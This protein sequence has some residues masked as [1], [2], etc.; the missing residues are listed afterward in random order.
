M[1]TGYWGGLLECAA[2]VKTGAA[3]S[4]DFVQNIN[5]MADVLDDPKTQQQN[6]MA[7]TGGVLEG[8]RVLRA[9]LELGDGVTERDLVEYGE[10]APDTV[11]RALLWA[12]PLGLIT[13]SAGSV[14]LMDPFVKRVFSGGLK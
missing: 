5:R 1:L 7:L 14:W 12:E 4:L 10:L 2:R 6:R 8:E 11:S 9:M 3:H 13:R